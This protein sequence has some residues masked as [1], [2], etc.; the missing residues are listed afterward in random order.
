MYSR[1]NETCTQGRIIIVI[2]IIITVSVNSLLVVLHVITHCRYCQLEDYY[3][4][5]VDI[6]LTQSLAL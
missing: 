6:R 1:E 5:D 4:P 3:S 2:I